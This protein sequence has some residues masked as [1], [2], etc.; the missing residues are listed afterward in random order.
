MNTQA[1]TETNGAATEPDS[2]EETRPTTRKHLKTWEIVLASFVGGTVM[3]LADVLYSPSPVTTKIAVWVGG[4]VLAGFNS[5]WFEFVAFCVLI[6]LGL[7][8]CFVNRPKT[9][10][11][12][13]VQGSSVIGILVSINIGT[14]LAG[15]AS[16][17]SIILEGSVDIA[18][19]QPRAYGPLGIGTFLTG[20]SIA[21]T[22]PVEFSAP[23]SLE[24]S[25]ELKVGDDV[26]CALDA[27]QLP[28]L[29]RGLFLPDAGQI[30]VQE[31]A[32]EFVADPVD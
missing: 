23:L 20:R 5:A 2:D 31:K 15:V 8:L 14:Q 28:P 29:T 25:S 11:G 4:R 19:Q 6:L 32:P 24:C 30:W 18:V 3:T 27:A 10:P 12:A 21:Q 13:F 16:A 22:M 1:T 7:G 26:Y 9:R 17:Q